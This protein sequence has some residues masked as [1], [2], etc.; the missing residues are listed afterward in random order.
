MR[1]RRSGSSGTR[2]RNSRSW[3]LTGRSE[4]QH[5]AAGADA[6]LD[7]GDVG[8]DVLAAERARDRDAVVAVA[9]EVQLAD[10]EDRDG[11][12][13]LAAAL[14]LRDPLPARAQPRARGAEGAVEVLRAVDGADDRVEGDRLQPEVVLADAPERVD[15]LLEREDV[16]DVVGLEAQPPREVGQHPRPPRPGEVALCVLGG[17]AG[18]HRCRPGRGLGA[19]ADGVAVERVV[20]RRDEGEDA[21]QAGDL[22]G[23]HDRLI[24]ADDHQAA[25]PLLE[26]AMRADQHPEARWNR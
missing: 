13:R 9:H 16:A 8:V 18:A 5:V 14:G 10:P 12:E 1:A 23:L 11:R 7:L 22:E 26:A 2:S 19:R 4:T 25:V 3:P 17:E 6:R 20:E 21:V 24:V 15:D